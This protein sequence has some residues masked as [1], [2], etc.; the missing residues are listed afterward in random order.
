[1]RDLGVD[2]CSGCGISWIRSIILRKFYFRY[3]SINFRYCSPPTCPIWFLFVSRRLFG[4]LRLVSLSV[5]TVVLWAGHG[6][7]K[8]LLPETL[9]KSFFCF[10]SVATSFR[11]VCNSTTFLQK[12][13]PLRSAGSHPGLAQR[14]GYSSP[15]R[16]SRL[17][18]GVWFDVVRDLLLSGNHLRG[19]SNISCNILVPASLDLNLLT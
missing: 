9:Q 13:S 8:H 16:S 7:G 6:G 11:K 2:V 10:H 12:K 14:G 15:R 1:M 4:G 3:C 5:H 19:K 17:P 18:G